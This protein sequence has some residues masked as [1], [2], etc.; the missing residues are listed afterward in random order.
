MYSRNEGNLNEMEGKE[1]AAIHCPEAFNCPIASN[2]AMWKNY[3]NDMSRQ[4]H[5]PHYHNY[6]YPPYFNPYDRPYYPPYNY[7]YY[8]Y[9][10][11]PY[12]IAPWL[13]GG[14]ILGSLF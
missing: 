11:S 1:Y 10:N 2:F 3:R 9:Y 14:L 6:D 8:N 5:R 12:N 7:P 13:L 4:Y